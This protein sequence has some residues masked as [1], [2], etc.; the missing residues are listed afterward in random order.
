MT[1]RY[2]VDIGPARFDAVL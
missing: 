1:C 2:V